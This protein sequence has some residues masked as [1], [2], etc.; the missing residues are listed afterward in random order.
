MPRTGSLFDVAV[1]IP[2]PFGVDHARLV[3][4]AVGYGSRL[5]VRVADVAR[6]SVVIDAA[7]S[8]E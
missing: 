8:P 3:A 7:G 2:A 4:P 6:R 5:N 1:P